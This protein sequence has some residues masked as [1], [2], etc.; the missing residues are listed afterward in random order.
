M[1]LPQPDSGPDSNTVSTHP[2]A[3]FAPLHRS[4]PFI[5]GLR[6]QAIKAEHSP[7]IAERS[8]KAVYIVRCLCLD[9]TYQ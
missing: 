1:N 7:Y 6:C 5:G 9:C 2:T 3:V 4:S 8:Q